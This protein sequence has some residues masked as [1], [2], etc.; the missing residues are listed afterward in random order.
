MAILK[1]INKLFN[2]P[3]KLNPK[4]FQLMEQGNREALSIYTNYCQK[5]NLLVDNQLCIQCLFTS[6][7]QHHPDSLYDIGNYYLFASNGFEKDEALAIDYFL[8]AAALNH[9]EAMNQLA[10][11]YYTGSGVEK[12]EQTMIEWYERAATLGC[13]K[14]IN[15]LGN[16]YA[17][18][19]G[20]EQSFQK[21][22]EY[23]LNAANKDDSVAMSNLSYLY[24]NGLGVEKDEKE[25]K[26][27]LIKSRKIRVKKPIIPGSIDI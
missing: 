19:I 14:A 6:A 26:D 16:I 7:E 13:S 21:A 27:W 5:F 11:I 20:V 10:Y 2:K 3:K 24:F 12:N 1:L 22:K 18:G 9:T 23:F 4:I 8:K 17:K 15:N 25:A